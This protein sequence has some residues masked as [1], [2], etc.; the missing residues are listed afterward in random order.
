MNFYSSSCGRKI[1]RKKKF[2]DVN[3]SRAGFE[4]GTDDFQ[5]QH[6]EMQP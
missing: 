6:E 3:M 4:P 5:L 1:I 2:L